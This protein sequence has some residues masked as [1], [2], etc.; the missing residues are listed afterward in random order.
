MLR[1]SLWLALAVSL[2][3][4]VAAP[5]EDPVAPSFLDLIPAD[6]PL[7]IAVPNVAEV[8]RRGEELLTET[9]ILPPVRPSD[10]VAGLV[11]FLGV[12]RGFNPLSPVAVCIPPDPERLPDAN[13]LQFG[14]IVVAIPFSDRKE[15]AANF[16]LN[17]DALAAGQPVPLAGQRAFGRFVAFRDKHAWLAHSE[18]ALRH[19]LDADRLGAALTPEHRATLADADIVLHGAARAWGL[20][21]E[22]VVERIDQHARDAKDPQAAEVARGLAACAAALRFGA[23]TC[24]VDQGL[25]FDA[26]TVFEHADDSPSARFL[27]DLAAGPGS[28]TL[29]GLP[30]GRIV[31]AAATR[32]DGRRNHAILAE[33][34]RIAA[35][36]WQRRPELQEWLRHS[37]LPAVFSDLRQRL[38]GMRLA[39]Y[40]NDDPAAHGPFSVA[41]VLDCEDPQEFLREVRELL[42]FADGGDLPPA[43]GKPGSAVEATRALISQ[44]GAPEFRVR[45]S[46]SVKLALLGEPALP[47]L[48]EAQKSDDPEV[49]FRARELHTRIAEAAAARRR[50]LFAGSPLLDVHPRYTWFA[51]TET[52]DGRSVDVVEVDLPETE[53]RHAER[54]RGLFG[55]DWRRIRVVALDGAVIAAAGSHPDLLAEVVRHCREGLE[56]LAARADVKSFASTGAGSRQ[57]QVHV[58]AGRL[59]EAPNA[60]QAPEPNIPPAV[61]SF[62]LSISPKAVRADVFV[63]AAEIKRLAKDRKW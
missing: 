11:N 61:S 33:W 45:E 48:N 63:P 21:W 7:A 52:L 8:R 18:E 46:A 29:A 12:N 44:L 40:E 31:V 50:E 3:A 27:A 26:L 41:V 34:A 28:S 32:G 22:R 16:G 20:N 14:R 49:A 47:L 15:M 55:P 19:A 53:R 59:L 37:T 2:G 43:D 62:G 42:H 36:F 30:D 5:A 60:D 54:L 57:L 25:R 35:P 10:V 56:G 24:R 38:T 4:T 13:V 1:T 58:A 9:G 23:V 6:A 51:G 17:P 39:V